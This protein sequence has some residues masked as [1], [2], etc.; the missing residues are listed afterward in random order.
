[1]PV[2]KLSSLSAFIQMDA[3]KGAGREYFPATTR[4]PGLPSYMFG[5]SCFD[6]PFAAGKVDVPLLTSKL[7]LFSNVSY[8]VH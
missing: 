2:L 4:T 5:K 3:E 7:S 1:M 6:L 8:Q